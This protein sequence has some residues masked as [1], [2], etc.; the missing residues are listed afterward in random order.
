MSY[1]TFLNGR[2]PSQLRGLQWL[3]MSD[4]GMVLRGTVTDDTGGGGTQT[5]GTASSGVACKTEPLTARSGL[6]AGRIDERST[7]LVSMPAGTDVTASD[8]VAIANRGTFEVTAVRHQTAEWV[9]EF[10]VIEVS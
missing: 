2:N 1:S 5:W 3:A 6:L 9:R 10:E 8:R 4:T 7:H